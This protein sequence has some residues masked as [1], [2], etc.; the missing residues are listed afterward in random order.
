MKKYFKLIA[1]CAKNAGTEILLFIF[2]RTSKSVVAIVTPLVYSYVIT[3]LLECTLERTIRSFLFLCTCYFI[4]AFLGYLVKVMHNH[5]VHKLN[6]EIKK[7]VTSKLFYI[8]PSQ[9]N[10]EYGKMFSLIQSDSAMISS[11]L[12][13]LIG[14]LFSIVTLIGIGAVVF[15]IN[16]KLALVLLCTYPINILVNLVYNKRLKEKTTILVEENDRYISLL[17]NSISNITDISVHGGNYTINRELE[18]KSQNVYDAALSQGTVRNNFS[19]A[20][21]AIGLINHLLLTAL[22][23]VF[24][25]YGYISFGD[26]VAFNTYSKSMSSALD[27]LISLNTMLQP[28]IVSI[29]RLLLLDQQYNRNFYLESQKKHIEAAVQSIELEKICFSAN[30]RT[31]INELSLKLNAGEIVG[32]RGE[33]ASGKTTIANLLLTNIIPTS[34][35]IYINGLSSEEIAYTSIVDHIAYVGTSKNL[36]NISVRNNILLSYTKSFPTETQIDKVCELLN[37]KDDIDHFPEKIDTFIT[38]Y[39]KLSSGQIQKIQLARALL[40]N[41][42]VLILDEAISNLDIQTKAKVKELILELKQS[43]KIIIIISHALED[44]CICDK[45][46]LV[47]NGL[48]FEQR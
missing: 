7:Q 29:D 24:V 15:Y 12:F 11:T 16:W 1:K 13:S 34:G 25:Y 2:L 35:K 26:F 22:G 23:I 30:N 14:A 47:K 36:F 6:F 18:K 3:N 21:N 38:D 8:P 10:I 44:Y 32:I 42:D 4:S 41:P 37:L 40:C 33:N 46:Y 39:T 17:K 27:S 20:V 31:I 19:S 48:L 43:G 9:L 45:N 5:L 28:G